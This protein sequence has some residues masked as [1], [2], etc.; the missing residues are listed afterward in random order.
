MTS[1]DI[2]T[3]TQPRDYHFSEDSIL[4][5]K[6]AQSHFDCRKVLDLCAGCGVVGIEY[7]LLSK[8]IKKL[9]FLEKQTSFFEDALGR[10]CDYL[11]ASKK[12]N[13]EQ[14]FISF[15]Q[16]KVD[17]KFDVILC[18][19]PYYNL[20]QNRTGNS[21]NRSTCTHF[22]INFYEELFEFIGRSLNEGGRAFISCKQEE[23]ENK[24]LNKWK[25]F[26]KFSSLSQKVDVITFTVM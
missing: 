11:L 2:F 22:D 1:T 19:P 7:A 5:A 6:Y 10:N 23:I 3:Y 18:N 9:S 16:Y 4:L 25:D 15:E 13:I 17:E 26:I 20:S 8:N 14:I 12:I 24:T 21:I